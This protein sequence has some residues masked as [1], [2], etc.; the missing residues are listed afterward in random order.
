MRT[1]P[2]IS[3]AELE[4]MLLLW[5]IEIAMVTGPSAPRK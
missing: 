4:L 1:L 2:H 3:D 5:K